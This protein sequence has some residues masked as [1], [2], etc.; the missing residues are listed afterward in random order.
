VVI[1]SLV[2]SAPLL[3]IGDGTVIRKDSFINGYRT[4]RVHPSV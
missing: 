4:R 1:L 3:S 2:P